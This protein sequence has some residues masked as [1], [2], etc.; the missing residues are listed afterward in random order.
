MEGSQPGV[1]VVIVVFVGTYQVIDQQE[2]DTAA[3]RVLGRPVH[4]VARQGAAARSPA[5]KDEVGQGVLEIVLA[6]G[7]AGADPQAEAC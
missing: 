2:S 3:R 4:G 6:A 5:G 7:G 1:A